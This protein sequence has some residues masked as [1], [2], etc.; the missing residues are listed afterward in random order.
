MQEFFVTSCLSTRAIKTAGILCR[1]F[2]YAFLSK[3]LGR[4]GLISA[5]RITAGLP[6]RHPRSDSWAI[7]AKLIIGK[8]ILRDRRERKN[9]V[10]PFHA[11]LPKSALIGLSNTLAKEGI[12]YNIHCITP[13]CLRR[14]SDSRRPSCLPVDTT[15]T[16]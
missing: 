5:A 14:D 9:D 10:N 12:K 15:H 6:S 1:G 4:L 2:I 7:L 13:S 11:A 3:P 8:Q 16:R